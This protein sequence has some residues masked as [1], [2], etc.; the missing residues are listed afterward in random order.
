MRVYQRPPEAAVVGDGEMQQF[1]DDHQIP[2]LLIERQQ[3]GAEVQ[4]AE[5]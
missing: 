4:A 3:I 1:V 5:P 2:Q